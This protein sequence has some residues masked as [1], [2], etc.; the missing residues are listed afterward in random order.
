MLFGRAWILE[1]P[2]GS[3]MF[4]ASAMNVLIGNGNLGPTYSHEFDQCM[5]GAHSEGTPVKKRTGLTS[6]RPFHS[7]P[8]QCDG[9]HQHCV[10]RG[11]DAG[12]SRTAQAAVYPQP[13]CDLLISE[14]QHTSDT[15]RSE[16]RAAD[17]HAQRLRDPQHHSHTLRTLLP[18]LCLL[19]EHRGQGFV[20]IF[21]AIVVPWARTAVGA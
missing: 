12:G 17:T 13:M 8:P 3:D 5:L 20:D 21:V 9:S 2:A 1:Q 15:I 14:M 19:A 10:L 11:S 18:E 7:S 4:R 6:N 16:G